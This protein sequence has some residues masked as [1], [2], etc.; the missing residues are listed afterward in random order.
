MSFFKKS[1]AAAFAVTAL[2]ALAQSASAEV[3]THSGCYAT[4]IDWC[5]A[6]HGKRTASQCLKA[7]LDYCDDNFAHSTSGGPL[8]LRTEPS[9]AKY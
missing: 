3:T 7:K 8:G 5:N 6:N 4:A 1:A 9:R 2:M